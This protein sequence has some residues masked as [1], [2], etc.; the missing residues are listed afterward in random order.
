MTTIDMQLY[1]VAEEVN[2]AQ[3]FLAGDSADVVDKLIRLEIFVEGAP[4][5]LWLHKGNHVHAA[6]HGLSCELIWNFICHSAGFDI[7]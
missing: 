2:K 1:Q 3:N 6:H 4:V 5:S 7:D